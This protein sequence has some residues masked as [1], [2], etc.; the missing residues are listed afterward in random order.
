M[1]TTTQLVDQLDWHWQQQ[2][3]PRLSGLT[4]DEYFWTPG[5]RA[6]IALLRA[7][8]VHTHPKGN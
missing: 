2:L 1:T 6:E 8:Y 4:D 7:L 5:V 3:R